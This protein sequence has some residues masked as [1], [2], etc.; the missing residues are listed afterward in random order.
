MVKW[1]KFSC[2]VCLG[3]A[4]GLWAC[5]SRAAQPA[6]RVKLATLAPKGS[7]FHHTLQQMGEKWREAPDGGVALTLFTDGSM[8]GEA[9][10]VRKMRIGQIQA[11]ALTAV[12]LAEINND[13]SALQ[14]MP[15]M[16]RSWDEV[17]HALEKLR[18][19][20]ER[21]FAEKGF[22][23]LFWTDAGWVRFFSKA[24]LAYPDD[25]KRMKLFAWAGSPDW[26]DVMKDLG[27][28]PV[29]L[30]TAEILPGLQTGLIDAVPTIPVF[31]NA[32]QF[33]NQAPHMLEMDWAPIVG[34]GV[35]TKKA[36]DKISP[37]AQQALRKAA[38]EA[39]QKIR[40]RSRKENE[41]AV[42]AMKKRGLKVQPLTPEIEAAWRKGVGDLYPKIRGKLVPAEMFDEVQKLLREY[43]ASG[44]KAS[45]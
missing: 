10:M 29:S 4:A 7:S 38:Q 6:N 37:A 43:R 26:L 24:P 42:E 45:P 31:A 28:K 3:L 19:R 41:E 34:G 35:I 2:W 14:L 9:D 18:P 22:V 44:A 12:G 20:L 1:R 39:G 16:F 5:Q 32:G 11:A 40:V 23:V 27:Y 17:E 21:N 8:G 33:Y 36:W 25:L 13:V 30:E 15:M